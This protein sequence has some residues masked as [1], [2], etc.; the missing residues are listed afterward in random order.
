[1]LLR[2]L[3]FRDLRNHAS[4]ELEC[5]DGILFLWGENGA[6]KTTLLEAIALLCLSKSFATSADRT[7]IRQ[8]AAGFFAAGS[9]LNPAGVSSEVEISY[10]NARQRKTILL[11]NAP[12]ASA[13]ELIG[14]FPLVILSPQHRPLVQ[15][16]PGERR[17]FADVILSQS[18]RSSLLDLMEYQKVLRHRNAL[19]AGEDISP[20]RLQSLIEPWNRSFAPLAARITLRRAQ[21]VAGFTAAFRESCAIVSRGKDEAELRYLPSLPVEPDAARF[22]EEILRLLEDAAGQE[23][24]RGQTLIGPHRDEIEIL[25]NG[26]DAR[27][28][29]SQGQ[30]KTVM[31]ALKMAEFAYL[32][33][34]LGEKPILLLDDVFSE[35]DR[36]RLA[37]LLTM[38][39]NLGQTFITSVDERAVDLFSAMRGTHKVVRVEKGKL[40]MKNEQ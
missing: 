3:R 20:S 15:G 39:E 38:A 18:H 21:F 37:G 36:E 27:Q 16:G 10:P 11:D 35:L 17:R 31:I 26:L 25:L 40:L 6:G 32:E 28:H 2:R 23:F 13:S 30:G 33:N 19:L 7:L 29:A 1:M 9:F 5:P 12:L 4:S 8:G 34:L 14:R 22:A 24:R